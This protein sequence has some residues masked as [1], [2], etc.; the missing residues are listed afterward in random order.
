MP[1]SY[2]ESP[3]IVI[4]SF[5]RSVMEAYMDLQL[6]SCFYLNYTYEVGLMPN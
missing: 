6:S 2:M 4:S 5:V 1:K 3:S